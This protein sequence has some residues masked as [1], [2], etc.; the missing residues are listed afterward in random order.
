MLKLESFWIVEQLLA[1]YG[2]DAVQT[3]QEKEQFGY[4][5]FPI[6]RQMEVLGWVGVNK[7]CLQRES[8]QLIEALVQ[9]QSQLDV[10]DLTIDLQTEEEQL[11]HMMIHSPPQKWRTIW[12]NK[13]AKRDSYRHVYFYIHHHNNAETYSSGKTG[14]ADDFQNIKEI[15]EGIFETENYFI[16]YTK[17]YYVWVLPEQLIDI[18]NIERLIHGVVNTIM[19]ECLLDVSCY[20]GESYTLPRAVNERAQEELDMFQNALRFDRKKTVVTYKDIIPILLLAAMPDVQKEALVQRLI[21]NVLDDKELL[22]T[23]RSFLQQNLN[24][25]ETAKQL[26]IHRNSMQYRLEKFQ[27]KT[28]LDVRQFEDA[29]KAYMALTALG[30]LH[31]N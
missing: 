28:G 6:L 22:L 7:T 19:S 18:E 23:V 3:F 5:T 30:M 25:S 14:Q 21:R 1:I 2:K 4:E 8:K 10:E 17:N 29:V 26:Y 13:G 24:V 15:V 31:K 27:D 9:V 12:E 11:W 16:P 20:I